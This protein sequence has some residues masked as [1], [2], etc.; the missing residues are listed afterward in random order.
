MTWAVKLGRTVFANPVLAA[1]GTFGFGLQF[2]K[3]ADRIGGVVTKGITLQPRAGNPPPRIHEFPGGILNSV[4]LENPGLD[5]FRKTVLPQ[6][7][8]LKCRVV[9][10]VAGFTTSEYVRIVE[11][12]GPRRVDAI[13]LNVSCPNVRKGGVAFGQNPRMVEKVTK[14]VRKHTRKTLIVKLTG[15]LVD[16][17]D[18]A[19]AAEQGGA[20][21]VTVLNTLFG[22]ALNPDGRPFLGGRTGGISGPALKPFALFCVDRVAA[23]VKLPVIGCGG[24]M[25]GRDALDFLS[26]G[27]RMVQVGTAS[28]VDPQAPLNVW[29][30]LRGLLRA[31]RTRKWDDIVGRTRRQD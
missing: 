14:A 10:N 17:V 22:L 4:G 26:A 8:K 31:G 5:E 29:Q 27:A 9:V 30:E 24:I 21:A 3:V 2:P 11:G 15:N 16:P 20:D 23:G 13:E 12:L 1:S 28:L 7:A 6:M 18:T 19:K 25:T